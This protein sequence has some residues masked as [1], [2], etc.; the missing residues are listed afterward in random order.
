MDVGVGVGIGVDVDAVGS[1]DSI[2]SMT[3][4]AP[5]RLSVPVVN[6]VAFVWIIG[7]TLHS[8]AGI[9]E[10]LKLTALP[11]ALRLT[12]LTPE[13]VTTPISQNVPG[14]PK[15][16]GTPTSV[17]KPANDV[18]A[19]WVTVSA[20]VFCTRKLKSK[21]PAQNGLDGSLKTVILADAVSMVAKIAS[22]TPPEMT[23]GAPLPPGAIVS[24]QTDG[25]RVSAI[26]RALAHIVFFMYRVF[27][28]LALLE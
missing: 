1:N 4:E 7:G 24:A 18:P 14:P 13:K 19:I 21:H 28:V 22:P 27:M 26:K 16:P 9:P 10:K 20:E 15:P 25:T 11:S 8:P 5:I 23:S 3:P 12:L 6:D 17:R 2:V